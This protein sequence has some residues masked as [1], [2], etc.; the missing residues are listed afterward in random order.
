MRFGLSERRG[1]AVIGIGR[2][3][4][5][6]KAREK[7]DGKLLT[8]LKRIAHRYPRYGYRRAWATLKRR[9][10]RINLKK[11]LRLWREAGL[12][13]KRRPSRVRRK[14]EAVAGPLRAAYPRHVV[15]YDFMFATTADGRMLKVLTV[16]DE[17]TREALVIGVDR[18]MTARQVM[19]AL[20]QA[21]KKG[22]WPEYLR[23]DNGPEFI[24]QEL[25]TWLKE[26]GVTTH[27]I[28]P[29]SP[30]ENPFGESFNDKLRT[31]CLNLELFETIEE[32]RRVLEAWRR[33]YN[34]ERP[35]SSLGYQTPAEVSLAWEE[36]R[37]ELSFSPAP[38]ELRSSRGEGGP[39]GNTVLLKVGRKP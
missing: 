1:C 9:G 26:R 21:F 4:V 31:E 11:V 18:R 8:E 34:Q 24:A 16:V 2:S 10:Q 36:T 3:S 19:W 38:S 30:W 29:A 28:A 33:Y 20:A 17:F 22:R 13:I 23:S 7:N 27:H 6:Y 37:K 15:T 14:R 25:E 5:Q 32:A 39:E 12:K 35:H